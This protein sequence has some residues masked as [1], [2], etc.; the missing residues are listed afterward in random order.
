MTILKSHILMVAKKFL[1]IESLSQIPPDDVIPDA[2]NIWMQSKQERQD[3]IDSISRHI[4]EEFVTFQFSSSD[5]YGDDESSTESSE[6][7]EDEDCIQK[8]A[9]QLLSM[10]LFYWE[11][12]DSIREGDGER[13]SRCFEYML[14][15]FINTGRKNYAIEAFRFL[16]PKNYKLPPR[17]ATQLLYSRFV[18]VHGHPG[19]NI[20]A[21]LHME[22][23]NA[24]GKGCIKG[25]GENKSWGK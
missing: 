13:L 3:L 17:Q 5:S 25:L 12:S 2:E 15:M 11:Y 24:V 16:C 21:N 9:K 4:I 7:D 22:H 18:N 1:H 20:A 8:Y 23:L 19:R 14:P 6:E 10:G